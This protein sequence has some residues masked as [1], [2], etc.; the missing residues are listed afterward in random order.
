MLGKICKNTDI[1]VLRQQGRVVDNNV[2]KCNIFAENFSNVSSNNNYDPIF[3]K[4]KES[5]EQRE[6][7]QFVE[8]F[9]NN[10]ECYNDKFTLQEFKDAID[11]TNNSATG[12]DKISNTMFKH[13]SNKT[14]SIFLLFIN[15]MW[16][17]QA[18][19]TSWKH[20]I[21]I[22]CFKNGK[23]PSDPSSYRPIALTSNFNKIVEKMV[24]NRLRWFLEKHKLYSN[25][26]S[27]F[28]KNR[29]TIEQCIR[30]ENEINK[31]VTRKHITIGIFID[32]QKAFDML[33]KFGLLK[34]MSNLGI[35]GNLL[36]YVNNFL[37]D[38]T[39]QVRINST[40]S[41]IFQVQNGTP[42]GSCISPTLFNI[43]VNDLSSCINNCEIS[44]FADDGAIWKSG[45][46][47]KFFQ[48]K[49][50]QDLDNLREWCLKWG[51]LISPTKTVAVIFTRKKN[52]GN[53]I[54]KLGSHTLEIVK[55]VKFLGMIFDYQ[56][57]WKKHIQYIHTRCTKVLNCMRL[58]T[59]TRWGASSRTLRNIYLTMIR[60]KIDYGCEVYNSAS[61]SVKKMLDSIQLQALR[62]C[63]GSMKSASL[64]AL[65]VE[66]GDPPYEI[67]RKC[68]IAKS[69]LNLN[70]FDDFHPAK[71]SSNDTFMFDFYQKN[72][73][74]KPFNITARETLEA[75]NFSTN[76]IYKYSECPFPPWEVTKPFISDQLH[77]IVSKQD[78]P[79]LVLSEANILIDT[80]YSS[81]LKV[82]TDGSKDPVNNSSG[83]A[84][85]I[86]ELK[87]KNCFKLP[88]HCSIFMC[89]LFAI[90]ASLSW[91]QDY[92]PSK[93]VIFVDSLS[94][95]QA[96]K[97]SIFK[98]KC[99]LIYDIYLLYHSLI[100]KGS[101]VILEWVPSHVGVTGN[102]LADVEA[103]K[104]LSLP[105]ISN[106]LP[107][108]KEDI[109]T[110][111]K[112]FI[113]NMWQKEWESKPNRNLY[114]ICKTVNFSVKIPELSR[115]HERLL[116]KLRNG[117]LGL[118]KHLNKIGISPTPPVHY[119]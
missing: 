43:M 94:A 68:L 46:S 109:K 98:V 50:Q 42:Q 95:L 39:L 15:R 81:Y 87:V 25:V 49:I 67:R 89:E 12:H 103:K 107:L 77:N 7:K 111:C 85:V 91:L 1:P 64:A 13:M 47:I 18:F 41:E 29:N 61:F 34:K 11:D 19:P 97:S 110:L 76:F 84:F 106:F 52:I 5:M 35:K 63:T 8:N 88:S 78:L 14:L 119:L 23:D 20:S 92:I 93:T 53:L 83:C 116:F 21:V 33:W 70:S 31:T 6:I 56:L 79:H 37:S 58:L 114:N 104:S 112:N 40:L 17:T 99:Q 71:I 48:K 86:P 105:E 55:E 27:G 44:Q 60:S 115:S 108:F 3:K 32:F 26:Q 113:K 62:I 117:Y 90:F 30:L 118:N 4:N 72:V 74:E 100:N 102:E 80:Q 66:M 28:R 75:N 96:L 36:A 65:Q 57:T 51:F 10:S 82:Y 9:T 24:N 22:P 2:D 59:G 45:A 54:L 73:K 38:R 16:F 101:T 69:Y